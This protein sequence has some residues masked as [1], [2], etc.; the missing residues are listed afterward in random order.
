MSEAEQLNTTVHILPITKNGTEIIGKVTSSQALGTLGGTEQKAHI[1]V[2]TSE[3][4]QDF[5]SR[6]PIPNS[7][8]ENGKQNPCEYTISRIRLL[9]SHGYPVPESYLG[10]NDSVWSEHLTAHGG[11]LWGKSSLERLS[12]NQVSPHETFMA[13]MLTVHYDTIFGMDAD[14]PPEHSLYWWMKKANQDGIVLPEDDAMELYIKPDGSWQ[15]IVVDPVGAY[16][17][18]ENGITH[19][20]LTNRNALSIKAVRDNILSIFRETNEKTKGNPRVLEQVNQ[21]KENETFQQVTNVFKEAI[22]YKVRCLISL[23]DITTLESVNMQS[24]T[25]NPGNDI[26]DLVMD[27][28][29]GED[30]ISKII[31]TTFEEYKAKNMYEEQ[32]TQALVASINRSLRQRLQVLLNVKR[33]DVDITTDNAALEHYLKPLD[34]PEGHEQYA[35]LCKLSRF[36]TSSTWYGNEKYSERLALENNLLK[37]GKVLSNLHDID[38]AVQ[39]ALGITEEM[40][41]KL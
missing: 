4:P 19:S 20:E 40:W 3:G 23:A 24:D 33:I 8:P 28:T 21:P 31:H 1:V 2:D 9:D 22:E 26:F 14:T 36:A 38:K 32:A 7:V 41:E 30:T 34:T 10:P 29:N 16:T 18:R 37:Q 25:S 15:W 17:Q 13:K 5:L 6:T 27:F 12:K 39:H 11:T 35:L